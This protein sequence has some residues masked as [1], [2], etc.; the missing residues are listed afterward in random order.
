MLQLIIDGKM[1]ALPPDFELGITLNNYILVER[2]EDATYPLTLSL[3][4]NRHIFGFPERLHNNKLELELPAQVKFGP[5]TLL[6]GRTVITD[7]SNEEVELFITTDNRTFWGVYSD[8]YIDELDLGHEVYKSS[9]ELLS[10]FDYS[11]EGYM[12]YVCVQLYDKNYNG[13]YYIPHFYNR[14][15]FV[16]QRLT[17]K[18]GVHENSFSPFMRLI[19][20]VERVIKACGYMIRTNDLRKIS[21]FED[22]L[23]IKRNNVGTTPVLDYAR[24]LPH[25]TVSEFFQEVERKFSIRLFVNEAGKEVSL[26]SAAEIITE[27]VLPVEVLDGVRKTFE[28][29]T[30][31][32]EQVK[33]YKFCDKEVSDPNW[34]R[35]KNYLSIVI[36]EDKDT[37][38]T[39]CISTIVAE[40]NYSEVVDPYMH[41]VQGEYDTNVRVSYELLTINTSTP[42]T[43][44]F[45]LAVYRGILNRGTT[46]PD[47]DVYGNVPIATPVPLDDAP[48][49]VSLL[50]TGDDGLYKRF[51]E[52][53]L[54]RTDFGQTHELQA[55]PDITVLSDVQSLFT[56]NIIVRN[57]RYIV[58]EEEI[59]LTLTGVSGHKLTAHPL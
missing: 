16:L 48:N 52:Q 33:N 57:Q 47:K 38:N 41:E 28:D 40:T 11:L 50:W 53:R 8:R 26:R 42:E 13:S 20:A 21:G 30:D 4:A 7:I 46:G 1:A 35:Y 5:Y 15:D 2:K 39:E 19:E 9:T 29:K 37:E 22:I 55:V 14:W 56:D 3:K 54:Q 58:E 43:P 34:Q 23:I 31:K 18:W 10:Y 45:R 6:S 59:S 44:E 12:P 36:G 49:K 27:S 25:L 32:T 51:H 17:R 24:L